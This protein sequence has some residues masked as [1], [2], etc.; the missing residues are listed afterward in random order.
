M[1]LTICKLFQQKKQPPPKSQKSNYQH[2][3]KT[4]QKSPQNFQTTPT[5]E[6]ITE[7]VVSQ[8]SWPLSNKFKAA[9]Y[10]ELWIQLCFK[11][12]KHRLHWDS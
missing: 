10:F 1:I 3:P 5:M 6:R 8:P 12:D 7:W 11:E 4:N 9:L 2:S